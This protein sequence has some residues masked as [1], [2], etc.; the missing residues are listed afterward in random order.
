MNIRDELGEAFIIEKTIS[1]EE[2]S[3]S[4]L[5][6]T[7]TDDSTFAIISAFADGF[8]P[9]ENRK[10]Q[11]AL[12]AEVQDKHWG[13]NE[14]V[15]RW[16]AD[17]V[18]YDEKSLLIK[19]ISLK[20]AFELSKKYN[21]KSFIFKDKDKIREICTTAFENYSPG[22]VV[23]TYHV[24]PKKPLNTQ[25]ASEI[26]SKQKEGPASKPVKG[27][28]LKPFQLQT[29]S[30]ELYESHLLNTR[31]GFTSVKILLSE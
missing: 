16:V 28:N 18:G 26:F 6:K 11:A 14:F 20:Q 30:F 10:R 19:G 31:L 12:K 9:A 23:R 3:T 29:E 7:L 25:L 17:N 2:A 5:V 1:L 4:R 22:D 24:D 13:F 21:Q 15:A 8:S 27:S